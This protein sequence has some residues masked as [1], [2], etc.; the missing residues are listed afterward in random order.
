[1]V[2]RLGVSSQP[3]ASNTYVSRLIH[4]ARSFARLTSFASALLFLALA[5]VTCVR[6]QS[7]PHARNSACAPTE[8]IVGLPNLDFV[9]Q[10]LIAYH[11]CVG[12]GGCYER[13]LEKIG[14]DALDFLGRYLGAHPNEKNLA[15]VIDIDETAL[16]NWENMKK[17]QFA[18]DHDE[19][20][21]WESQAKAPAIKPVLVLFNYARERQVATIFLT[22][23]S[24]S[25]RDMTVKDLEAA[26]Y[27]DWTKL[28]LRNGLSSA[29]ADDYKASE[30]KRLEQDGYKIIVN[31]GDQCSDLAGGY[32][33]KAFKLPNPFYYIP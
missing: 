2:N 26:G 1:M 23:R 29:L 21:Q 4:F 12:N 7:S 24:Y 14:G 22:G 19:T 8:P 9:E 20:L 17:M 18:Y 10:K 3:S 28:V 13:D 11:D 33:L 15:I 16:S 6:G 27:E 25:E 32:A 5:T 31:I 30:R